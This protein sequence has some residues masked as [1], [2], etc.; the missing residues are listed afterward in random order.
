ML[1]VSMI[2]L[3]PI[4]ES[5]RRVV[6]PAGPGHEVLDRASREQLAAGVEHIDPE[7]LR[8][9][10]HAALAQ[11]LNGLA[12][13]APPDFREASHATNGLLAFLRISAQQQVGNAFLR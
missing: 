1:N 9:P 3:L 13:P 2:G 6:E 10:D 8:P 12:V 5:R 4:P 11:C 7:I